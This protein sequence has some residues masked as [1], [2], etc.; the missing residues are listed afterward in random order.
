MEKMLVCV[1]GRRPSEGDTAG[2]TLSQ[3]RLVKFFMNTKF[4]RLILTVVICTQTHTDTHPHRMIHQQRAPAVFNSHSQVQVAGPL[5]TWEEKQ[6]LSPIDVIG[7]PAG[8]LHCV[9]HCK[10]HNLPPAPL[11]LIGCKTTVRLGQR[12]D[13]SST[14]HIFLCK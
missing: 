2:S 9:P 11:L 5:V 3:F 14:P 1:G 7:R 13:K 8:H 6:M 12:G 4:V 10:I